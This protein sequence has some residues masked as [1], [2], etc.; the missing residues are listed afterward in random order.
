MFFTN[1]TFVFNVKL[2]LMIDTVL[3]LMF[4][5]TN[6]SFLLFKYIL[7]KKE[8]ISHHEVFFA[9]QIR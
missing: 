2:Y 1:S 5:Y 3:L 7:K 9:T 8:R 4:K 6:N